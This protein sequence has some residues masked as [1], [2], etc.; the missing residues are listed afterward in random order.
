MEIKMIMT[1]ETKGTIVYSHDAPKG[2]QAFQALYVQKN[3]E[4]GKQIITE[5]NLSA[6]AVVEYSKDSTAGTKRV[7]NV[8][9]GSDVF[10][11]I[12]RSLYVEKVKSLEEF[13][14][15]MELTVKASK[16]SVFDSTVKETEGKQYFK[17]IKLTI[18]AA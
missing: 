5:E 9:S 11:A 15:K 2:Q 14:D 12:G 17:N 1:K 18:A 6:S 16:K 13:G 7:F 10:G 3:D 4:A 8:V